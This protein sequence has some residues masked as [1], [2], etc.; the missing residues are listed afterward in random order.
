M[1]GLD[2]ISRERIR[3]WRQ[4]KNEEKKQRKVEVKQ[5]EE[6]LKEQKKEEKVNQQKQAEEQLKEDKIKFI[7]SF[8]VEYYEI[9]S[10]SNDRVQSSLIGIEINKR[11]RPSINSIIIKNV[12]LSIQGIS[13]KKSGFNFFCGLK[14]K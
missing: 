1:R 9:T 8:I 12:L 7:K 10:N 3:I 5:R 6:L 11:F 4:E 2:A 14:L 13:S